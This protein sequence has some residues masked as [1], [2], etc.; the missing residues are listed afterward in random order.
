MGRKIV[1][2]AGMLPKLYQVH[3]LKLKVTSAA[4]PLSLVRT[5]SSLKIP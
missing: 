1:D 3:V 2:Q 5:G 4:A